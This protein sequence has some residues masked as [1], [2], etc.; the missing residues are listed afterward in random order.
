MNKIKPIAIWIVLGLTSTAIAIAGAAKLFGVP[1]LHTSFAIMGFP[2]WFGYFIG[3]CELFGAIGL[4]IRKFSI[5]AASGLIGIM[6]GAIYFH[7]VYEVASHA[8]PAV[9][10]LVLLTI[11]IFIRSKDL[12]WN[13]AKID[14]A[15]NA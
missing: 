8:V 7:F 11:I 4:F 10:L 15:S 3:A 6:L 1:A 2:V 14:S 9:I 12:S 5:I 13:S